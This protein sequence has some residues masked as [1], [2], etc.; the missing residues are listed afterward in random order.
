VDGS[1]PA[2][3]EP[4]DDA[5]ALEICH[6]LSRVQPRVLEKLSEKYVVPQALGVVQELPEHVRPLQHWLLVVQNPPELTQ[7][8][9]HW[10]LWQV[11]PEQHWL[12]VEQSE[13]D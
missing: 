2:E 3:L 7:G 10:P 11:S 12:L 5:S 6:V 13:P 9:A 8:V 1:F 4:Q